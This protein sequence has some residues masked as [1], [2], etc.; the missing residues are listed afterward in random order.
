MWERID[1]KRF[2]LASHQIWS[3]M[4]NPINPNEIFA[5]THSSGIY[6]INRTFEA[7]VQPAEVESKPEADKTGH[8][9][10]GSNYTLTE[11]S[12]T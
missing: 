3:L 2:K 7:R 4:F 11:N 12:V 10:E 1:S 5:G 6:R 9:I 8:P